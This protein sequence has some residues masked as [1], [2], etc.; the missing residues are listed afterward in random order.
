MSFTNIIKNELVN[1]NLNKLEQISEMSGLLKNT[2]DTS[3]GFK[4]TTENA[5]V[6]KFIFKTLKN[7]YDVFIKVSVR[8]GYNYNK[9]YIYVLE[10]YKN[11][12][13]IIDDLSLEKVCPDRYL[14]DDGDLKR[15]YLR[16]VFL[17][18]GSI[19]DPKTSQY[20]MELIFN[21]LS[22]ATFIND[23]LNYY[24]LNSK[25]LKRDNRYMVYI[26]ESEK[27]SDFLRLI[28][29]VNAV[30]YYENIRIYRNKKNNLNRINNCE[31]ANVDKII[32]TAKNQ[33][34]DIN[35]INSKDAFDL[36][37]DKVKEVCIYRLKYPE[38]S[39]LELSKIISLETNSSITKSG[40]HHRFNKLK[41]LVN[42]LQEKE[43]K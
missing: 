43:N 31:Q 14:I 3:Y 25:C 8:R 29:A 35:Y 11:Y 2:I 9:N 10:T 5:S 32:Q 24:N 6:A 12:S 26:K 7:N 38:V 1:I 21:N 28:G 36:L 19:N 30:L 39:L 42:T 22:Y 15:A 40:L 17:A 37:D 20:H 41:S 23:S 34:D 16:G 33:I 13:I 18:C 27:I 4:I